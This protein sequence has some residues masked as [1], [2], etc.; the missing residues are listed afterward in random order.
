M[1]GFLLAIIAGHKAQ[2]VGQQQPTDV[3]IPAPLLQDMAA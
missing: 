1:G 2:I 3:T